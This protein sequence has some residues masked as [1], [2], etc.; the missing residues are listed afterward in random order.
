MTIAPEID[1]DDYAPEAPSKD[2]HRV[3]R[4]VPSLPSSTKLHPYYD[5]GMILS[6]HAE[7]NF[8]IGGR[9][10]GKTYGAKKRAIKRAIQYGEM[11]ILL[12]RHKTELVKA[13]ET[14]FADIADEFPEWEFRVNGGNFEMSM[15]VPPE[16]D[17][18]GKAKKVKKNW[19]LIGYAMAL[20]VGQQ[21]KG[22]SFH[23]VKTI[24]FDE[25]IKEDG[26]TNY[27]PNEVDVFRNFFSTVDRWKDKTTVFF[28]ANA[29]SIANPYFIRFGILPKAGTTF[30]KLNV[31]KAKGYIVVH[32]PDAKDFVTSVMET[33]FGQMIE[34]SDYAKMA[35]LNEFPDNTMALV[36]VKN[37]KSRFL[38]NFET[39]SGMLSV[40][41]D[42]MRGEYYA[43]E[44]CPPGQRTVTMRM[45]SLD[46]SK[47]LLLKT[48]GMWKRLVR[49]TRRKKFLFENPLVRSMWFE[50]IDQNT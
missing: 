30:M 46:E 8:I 23:L 40:W 17:E 13:K 41:E 12:R 49:E 29:L 4:M 2:R 25:F 48:D 15:F 36:G 50:L 28:L 14:F 27:L 44:K 18:E 32:F 39:P 34:G 26:P 38:F 19:I 20:S 3:V 33:R 43:Y 11:F 45:S 37:P 35:L 10:L 1:F 7:W 9:G 21:A 22:S 42:S 24:I 6:H 16:L 47:I 31:G 5:Y